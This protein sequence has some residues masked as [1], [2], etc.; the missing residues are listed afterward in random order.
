MV[1]HNIGSQRRLAAVRQLIQTGL[2]VNAY[3]KSGWTPL[4]RAAYHGDVEVARELIRANADVNIKVKASGGSVLHTATYCII[5]TWLKFIWLVIELA[6][7]I[8]SSSIGNVIDE[9]AVRKRPEAEEYWKIRVSGRTALHVAAY[10]GHQAL[11]K[12]FLETNIGINEQD[13]EGR[14]ALM[15]A[16]ER[17][18]FHITVDSMTM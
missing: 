12:L 9:Q 5:Q 8:L 15:L 10:Y 4:L 3:D 2:D 17:G 7:A 1:L 13:D 18:H 14:T 6:M 11:L 16:V